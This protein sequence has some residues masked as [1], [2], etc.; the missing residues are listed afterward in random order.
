[1]YSLSVADNVVKADADKYSVCLQSPEI[2]TQDSLTKMEPVG[3]LKSTPAAKRSK[4]VNV[5][6][7]IEYLT[8]HQFRHRDSGKCANF[9]R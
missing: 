9:S 3:N 7:A 4:Y 6:I 8:R 5:Y 2:N 1:M